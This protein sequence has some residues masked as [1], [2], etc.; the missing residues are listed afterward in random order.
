MRNF[1]ILVVLIAAGFLTYNYFFK[2]KPEPPPS[3]MTPEQQ[4]TELLGAPAVPADGLGK[5]LKS[6]PK[7]ADT[8]LKN[9]TLV[10]LGG[11]KRFS[12]EGIDKN[13][14]RLV[15]GNSDNIVVESDLYKYFDVG[16]SRNRNASAKYF[17]QGEELL[18]VTKKGDPV[19]IMCRLG[20]IVTV[21]AR[22]AGRGG[23]SFI[24]DALMMPTSRR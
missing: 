8:F 17:I 20:E 6:H 11:I 10:I 3:P 16:L 2:P 22:Y 5:L 21:Q 23:N 15:L 7:L 13:R 24:F 9:R 18:Y 14:A 1:I 19:Q 12:V 4:F